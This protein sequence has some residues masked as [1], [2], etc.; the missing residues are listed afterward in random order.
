MHP[1]D[2]CHLADPRTW[3]LSCHF[4]MGISADGSMCLAYEHFDF[5]NRKT[6]K[7]DWEIVKL[8]QAQNKAIEWKIVNTTSSVSSLC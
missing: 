5:S 6:F 1:Q 8:S 2:L 3:E 4:G 7:S